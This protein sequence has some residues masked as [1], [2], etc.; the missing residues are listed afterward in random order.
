MIGF[1]LRLFRAEMKWPDPVQDSASFFGENFK[2]QK[3]F[4]CYDLPGYFMSEG[5]SF[6][7]FP[8]P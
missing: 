2:R 5:I 6:P 1:E 4:G 7:I 3:L 8:K